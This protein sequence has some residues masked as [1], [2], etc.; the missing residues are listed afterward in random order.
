M[1]FTLQKVSTPGP[2]YTKQSMV[3]KYLYTLKCFQFYT[4]KYFQFYSKYS[5]LMKPKPFVIKNH[6]VACLKFHMISM[7]LDLFYLRLESD[8]N[9]SH[10]K[11]LKQQ[12]AVLK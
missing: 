12:E 1:V 11:W 7:T 8:K 2:L 3:Y 9:K 6:E 4:L 5:H 10:S